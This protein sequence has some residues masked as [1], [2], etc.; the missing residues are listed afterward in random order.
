MSIRIAD[1]LKLKAPKVSD[2]LV[3]VDGDPPPEDPQALAIKERPRIVI[4]ICRELNER[5]CFMPLRVLPRS[6]S[7][8]GGESGARLHDAPLPFPI[9]SNTTRSHDLLHPG[10]GQ[11]DR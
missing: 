3:V 8:S 9:A 6:H 10:E 5:R 4:R 2:S 11:L 1:S 7:V